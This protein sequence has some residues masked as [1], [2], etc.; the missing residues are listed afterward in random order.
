MR[1]ALRWSL[2]EICASHCA[3]EVQ[4][5]ACLVSVVVGLAHDLRDAL[6]KPRL[7]LADRHQ[8][9][10]ARLTAPL[11]QLIDHPIQCLEHTFEQYPH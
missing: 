10:P 8:L 1:R 4:P 9:A 6:C 2:L 3:L 7:L 5:A 11:T